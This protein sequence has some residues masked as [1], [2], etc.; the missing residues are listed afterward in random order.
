MKNCPCGNLKPYLK[1]CKPYIDGKRAAPTAETLMRSRYSAYSKAKIGYIQNTMR[2]PANDQFDPVS[3]KA[4]AQANQWIKLVVIRSEHGNTEDESGL[5]EFKA[6]YRY[7]GQLHT[8]HEESLFTKH[9]GQWYYV[10]G[11][12]IDN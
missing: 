10:S 2:S 1:C 3:A 8:M 4:W 5:V 7:Q 9:D 12:T 11:K 6:T